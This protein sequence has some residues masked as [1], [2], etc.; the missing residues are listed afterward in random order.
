MS[1]SSPRW[2]AAGG[3]RIAG[4]AACGG[5][6]DSPGFGS[7]TTPQG[8]G[9]RPSVRS[10]APAAEPLSLAITP[11]A[12]AKKLPVSAEIGTSS[13]TA[14]RSPTV[15]LTDDGGARSSARAMRE[16]GSAW[17]PATPL[18]YG[19]TYTATRHRD[20]RR[21]ATTDDQDDLVHHDGPS[22]ATEIG[23]GLYL[24]DD[25]TYGVAM[26]VVVEFIPGIPKKD[27]A[28]VQKRHVR[29]DRPAAA[30]RLALDRPTAPR[31]TTGRRSTGS[32]ARR[33]P[34][35]SRWRASRWATAGTATRT[36]RR[37]P[38]SASK[39]EMKV[40][41]KTKKMTVVRGRQGWSRR[42]RSAWARRHARRPAARWW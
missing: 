20:R 7:D 16:D 31:P 25:K 6:D 39:F 28:A 10:R 30:G 38:R 19:T 22:R 36:A 15:T 37:P 18:K 1:D 29:R 34:C 21:T 24:F 2:S 32:R 27:R 4:L 42:C 8:H 40:D 5:D 23:T 9:G 26:P 17:V 33:S 11:A 14:A 13:S 3:D 12:G 35:G 41:N